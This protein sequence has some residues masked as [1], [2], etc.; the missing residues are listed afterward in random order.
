MFQLC[1]LSLKP[2]VRV[3]GLEGPGPVFVEAPGV[4]RLRLAAP[5]QNQRDL[6]AGLIHGDRTADALL[7]A[8]DASGAALDSQYLLARLEKLG[9]LC[10]SLEWAKRPALTLEPL[11]A[12]F[13]APWTAPTGLFRLSR[14][15][16]LRRQE[17]GGI[18]LENPLGFGR[19]RIHQ[20]ALLG[21]VGLLGEPT[22]APSLALAL[23]GAGPDWSAA[24]L[25][26]L[27]QSGAVGPC[28]ADGKLRE[29]RDPALRQWEFHDLLFHS[30]SR[31][32]RHD[33][34]Y[35]ATLRFLGEIPPLPALKTPGAG[36][37]TPLPEPAAG[38]AITPFFQVLA[39][40]SSGRTPGKTPMT[41]RQLGEF[42]HQVARVRAFVPANP[43]DPGSYER[44]RRPCASGG[45]MHSIE[46]YLIV[47]RCTGLEPGFYH[48][49]PATHAL[50]RLRDLDD[51]VRRF[52]AFGQA[53]MRADAPPDLLFTLAARFQR[54]AWK[55]QTMAYATILKDTGAMFQ[56]M[57][58]VATALGLAPC[59]IGCGDAWAFARVAGL[60]D[61][62]ETSVGEFALSASPGSPS[63]A[64]P[65]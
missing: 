1:I 24:C 43:A 39:E 60:D 14:F 5:S 10:Y 4:R 20:P 62:Q 30:R 45:A 35:G 31:L 52:L 37:R 64:P 15:A 58:L 18:L 33:G 55:Y 32:G 53:S 48:Y 16:W 38:T 11:T 46:L 44:T 7:R 8:P 47:A 12:D 3:L 36:P 26:L 19:I 59:A 2:A 34:P 49:D 29:D 6:L 9:W 65:R 61:L 13:Q 22:D 28:D 56:Q 51:E 23:P 21:L 17:G 40:R 63:G 25:A 50:E 57:Y 27:L 41:L 42:L 54:V